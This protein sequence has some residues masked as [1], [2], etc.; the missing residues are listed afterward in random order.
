M[1]KQ[2]KF[3]VVA[4]AKTVMDTIKYIRQEDSNSA[5]SVDLKVACSIHAHR[6]IW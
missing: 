5:V 2:L 3:Y 6:T 1:L 4:T